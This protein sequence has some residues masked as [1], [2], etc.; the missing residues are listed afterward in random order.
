M[1][2]IC[3]ESLYAPFFFHWAQ[4]LRRNGNVDLLVACFGN[5]G[6]WEDSPHAGSL[7]TVLGREGED[8]REFSQ[9]ERKE[10]AREIAKK[11][12]CE[13]LVLEGGSQFC[14]NVA[15]SLRDQVKKVVLFVS[16]SIFSLSRG[17]ENFL[18]QCKCL[19]MP[20]IVFDLQATKERMEIE[21]GVSFQQ[22]PATT[23]LG[24]HRQTTIENLAER[25]TDP[26]NREELFFRHRISDE[27]QRVIFI[28]G[29]KENYDGRTDNPF[30]ACLCACLEHILANTQDQV[31]VF[32]SVLENC[33]IE[34]QTNLS[35]FFHHFLGRLPFRLVYT[36]NWK[37]ASAACSLAFS[38]NPEMSQEFLYAGVPTLTLC[39]PE[40]AEN[41]GLSEIE[42]FPIIGQVEDFRQTIGV[43]SWEVDR[44]G[45]GRKF[46][47][48]PNWRD[49][50][51][52]ALT[53]N[54]N[55]FD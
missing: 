36:D 53:P 33:P 7:L 1:L 24:Y 30:M 5:L 6:G 22:G 28:T 37:G 29:P 50:L 44:E 31:I 12:S 39:S 20:K 21:S 51:Y 11:L 27:G 18:E 23:V 45:M 55:E 10:F 26:L 46:G 15:K 49:R 42:N 13:V 4:T 47:F 52:E 8:F 17:V 9:V 3:S 41:H 54:S 43:S 2:A 25:R 40:D 19:R 16:R 38:L 34:V 35:T 48:D 32:Y 14:L